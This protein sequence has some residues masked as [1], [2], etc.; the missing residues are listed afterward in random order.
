LFIKS[1][2]SLASLDLAELS[3]E[4]TSFSLLFGEVSVHLLAASDVVK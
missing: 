3:F 2:N 4:L 1:F